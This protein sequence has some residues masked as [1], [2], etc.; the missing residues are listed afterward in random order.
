MS[1]GKCLNPKSIVVTLWWASA[2]PKESPSLCFYR[3]P[4]SLNSQFLLTS[5]RCL[6]YNIR[7]YGSIPISQGTL[8]PR[9]YQSESKEDPH[10]NVEE[11]RAKAG[12]TGPDHEAEDESTAIYEAQKLSEAAIRLRR[13]R[14][15][16]QA[17]VAKIQVHKQ[18]KAIR[19]AAIAAV[20]SKDVDW[21][22][23][24]DILKRQT[25]SGDA[26]RQ[27]HSDLVRLVWKSGRSSSIK[28]IRPER[29]ACPLNWTVFSFSLYVRELVRSFVT[30]L[31]HRRLYNVSGSH[32]ES[33]AALLEKLFDNRDLFP[34]WSVGACND[35]LQYLCKHS[36]LR[37]ARKLLSNM[38]SRR[39]TTSTETVNIMLHAAAKN[40]NI[41]AFRSLLEGMVQ[42]NL[43]PDAQTWQKFY[44]VNSRNSIRQNVYQS[45][46]DRGLLSDHRSM[47]TFLSLNIRDILGQELDSGR[48]I[49]WFLEFMDQLNQFQ[50]LSTRWGTPSLVKSVNVGLH[51]T[52]S[53]S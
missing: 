16:S 21:R 38:E 50:W 46:R 4:S 51:R 41:L 49:T 22:D 17:A 45:M 8:S 29:I 32:V 11:N 48:S 19:R 52:L 7:S 31:L 20:K 37:R 12:Y 35:A 15:R 23:L 28:Q 13:R 24:F 9:P 14:A 2:L 42:S 25:N 47:S 1:V 18:N 3:V 10:H 26:N 33:V 27:Q 5:K 43:K 40:V 44:L 6:Q 53:G 30:P 39:F 36:M 34:Y